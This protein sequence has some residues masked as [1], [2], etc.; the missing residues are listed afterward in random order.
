MHIQLQL[1]AA[2]SRCI[3]RGGVGSAHTIQNTFVCS[4]TF[5]TSFFAAIIAL[6]S[7]ESVCFAHAQCKSQSTAIAAHSKVNWANKKAKTFRRIHWC[8][9]KAVRFD[10][11]HI[12][13]LIDKSVSF[14]SGAFSVSPPRLPSLTGAIVSFS[15]WLFLFFFVFI[16]CYRCVWVHFSFDSRSN[17]RSFTWM[18]QAIVMHSTEHTDTSKSPPPALTPK[19]NDHSFMSFSILIIYFARCAWLLLVPDES[20]WQ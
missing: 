12:N 11:I 16:F 14:P 6:L 17:Y 5:F 9:L 13:H 18:S 7:S 3:C 4:K 15:N 1:L 20:K 8:M 19:A 10:G 2:S